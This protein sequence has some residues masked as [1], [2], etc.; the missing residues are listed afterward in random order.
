MKNL[1]SIVAGIEKELDE[2]DKVREDA[3]RSSRELVRLSKD[4][5]GAMN[6]HEDPRPL[7][8]KMRKDAA[9]LKARASRCPEIYAA[10]YVEGA[11]AE[12]VEI[13]VLY[14][15]VNKMPLP[16]PKELCATPE[17]YLLGL[18]DVIGE[19]RRMAVDALR[20]MHPEQAEAR[21]FEMETI[22]GA[23]MRFDYP[24]A[25]VP[26]R[27]KQDVARGLVE[28]TRGEV[29][30]ARSEKALKD[31]LDRV[32]AHLDRVQGGGQGG[33]QGQQRHGGRDRG[34]R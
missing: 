25:V 31:K 32:A 8:A 7:L 34:R 17:A 24:D 23:L 2:K 9:A 4:I 20:E 3:L 12:V 27:K 5:I 28:R 11:L 10:G 30:V 21:L 19:L 13:C 18:G 29:L 1:Q 15:I 22:Y 14:A 6:R 33:Q 26:L 16:T